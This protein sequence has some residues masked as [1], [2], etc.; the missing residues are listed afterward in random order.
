[1]TFENAEGVFGVISSLCGF[2]DELGH[3]DLHVV[4]LDFKGFI[5]GW[6][7]RSLRHEIQ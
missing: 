4:V 1:M 2:A 7:E 5:G 6:S 3:D